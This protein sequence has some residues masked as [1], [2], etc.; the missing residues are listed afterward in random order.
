MVTAIVIPPAGSA[1][2]SMINIP[3]PDARGIP[4][5]TVGPPIRFDHTSDHAVFVNHSHHRVVYKNK[6]YPMA[7]HLLE[8]IKF[9]HQ[10]AMQERIRACKDVND[11][12]PLSASLQEHI[13]SDWGQVFL[14][15]VRGLFLL[16]ILFTGTQMTEVLYLKFKRLP[17]LRT[18]L[19]GTGLANIV[20][21]DDNTYWGDGSLGEG[22]NE[23]GKALVRL[24]ERLRQ[25]SE[26]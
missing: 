22:A 16:I 26:N 23:L 10:P 13:R 20:Y 8:A 4:V 6:M 15:T 12:Y 7:L 5:P 9:T 3:Q 11:M 24:G 18:L 17:S 2:T 19:L 25:E 14:K 21:A 1:S